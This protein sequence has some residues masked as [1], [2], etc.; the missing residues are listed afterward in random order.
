MRQHAK[1]RFPHRAEA[2][3]RLSQSNPDFDDL[4]HQYGRVVEDLRA[5]GN[6][7]RTD[8]YP[9]AEKLKR[10]RVAL[11]EELLLYMDSNRA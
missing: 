10:R 8:A 9:E 7:A 3:E 6:S 11:E 5:L 1:E 4:C 2:I